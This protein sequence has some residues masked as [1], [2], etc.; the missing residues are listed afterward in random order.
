MVRAGDAA[1]Q[2]VNGLGI[3][4]VRTAAHA[5]WQN[6]YAERVI[7]SIRRGCLDHVI[8]VIEAGLRRILARYLGY[9]HDT[10]THLSLAK[11]APC[12]RPVAAPDVGPIVT[13]PQGGGLHHRYHRR[14]A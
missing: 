14:A 8:I 9:Y 13:T 12:S 11:D 6:A 10:R 2:E 3:H 1:D 5:P 4:P 7:G